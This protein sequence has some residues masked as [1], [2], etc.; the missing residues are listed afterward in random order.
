MFTEDDS[1]NPSEEEDDDDFKIRY[2]QEKDTYSDLTNLDK[3][4]Y[5]SD[6]SQALLSD[7]YTRY[8]QGLEQAESLIRKN[9]LNDLEIMTPSLLDVLFRMENKFE[10][11]KFL[12][13]KYSAIQAL[14][15][16]TQV[17]VTKI[18]ARL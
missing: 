18:F 4:I 7:D 8:T 11:E 15:E 14:C 13:L 17:A 6:L 9:K 10:L 1:D 12:E 3:P 5:L 16:T 2:K